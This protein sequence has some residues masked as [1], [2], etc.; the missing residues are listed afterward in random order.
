MSG[1][2]PTPLT[3]TPA[4]SSPNPTHLSASSSTQRLDYF[5]RVPELDP[6]G[7]NWTIY[8]ERWTIAVQGAGLGR[9]FDPTVTM[10]V[11]SST[12]TDATVLGAYAKWQQEE[13][14]ARSH[15]MGTLADSTLRKAVRGAKT[16]SDIWQKLVNEF[17]QKSE[18]MKANL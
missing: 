15:L 5:S 4:F 1:S 11:P 13:L 8:R 2:S 12:E 14:Q 17:E 6:K 9:H 16:V 18:V 10:A 7:K 3:T